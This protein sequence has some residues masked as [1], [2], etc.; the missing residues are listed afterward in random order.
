MCGRVF[1]QSVWVTAE[2]HFAT[3]LQRGRKLTLF[4]VIGSAKCEAVYVFTVR[5]AT[6]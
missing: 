5:A 2:H 6:G 1:L 3:V 4:V